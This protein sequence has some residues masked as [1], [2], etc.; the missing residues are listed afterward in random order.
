MTVSLPYL[1]LILGST[2]FATITIVLKFF[3]ISIAYHIVGI[4]S[5]SAII[6][7][8]ILETARKKHCKDGTPYQFKI[9]SLFH[10]PNRFIV[11]LMYVIYSATVYYGFRKT[12]ASVG[13]PVYMTYPILI[14]LFSHLINK[15]PLNRLQLI[16]V[17]VSFTGVILVA[18]SHL[19]KDTDYMKGVI[20]LMCSAVAYALVYV[21]M[22]Y[23]PGRIFLKTAA[24]S[25]HVS[26][27]DGTLWERMHMQLYNTNT[28]PF[29]AAILY[30]VIRKPTP[31]TIGTAT[32]LFPIYILIGYVSQ[33]CY[34]Y[35]YN[36]IPITTYGVL[37]NTAVIVALLIGRFLLGEKI[38]KR[39]I[40]G[41]VFIIAG[42]IG[43]TRTRTK[44]NKA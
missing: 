34:L 12:P 18:Y 17:L 35:A 8:Y 40:L 20:A 14:L 44:I 33:I 10:N 39:R 36:R 31:P 32:I 15:S 25:A 38:N 6:A 21:I 1:A 27:R 13:I 29:I 22:Q 23:K 41:V 5:F 9:Q 3:S 26:E 43:E 24:T 42:V 28:L 7:M 4:S 37:D 30:I 11:G 19:D 16:S 2:L